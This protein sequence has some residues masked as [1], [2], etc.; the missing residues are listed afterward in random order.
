MSY[1]Y[2]YGNKLLDF[3][4]VTLYSSQYQVLKF[5]KSVSSTPGG[6]VSPV[7]GRTLCPPAARCRDKKFPAVNFFPPPVTL[8]SVLSA[9]CIAQN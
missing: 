4:A 2:N 9:V 6:A 1:Q 8:P 3:C 5:K 7:V